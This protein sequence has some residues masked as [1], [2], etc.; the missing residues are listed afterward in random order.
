MGT[1]IYLSWN[2]M[3]EEEK[4]MQTDVGFDADAGE[5]GYLRASIGMVQENRLLRMLFP[6]V[7][8]EPMD[9]GLSYDF[10]KGVELLPKAL[11]QYVAGD[12]LPETDSSRR[13]FQMG[14]IVAKMMTEV[15]DAEIAKISGGRDMDERV[16]YARSVLRFFMFGM[17]LQEEGKN[18][19]VYISW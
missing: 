16:R 9:E 8:W 18:P 3:D 5:I 19:K 10:K 17:R 11:S 15:G 6:E 2:G 7:H 4:K 1:D 12:E 13:Q 14:Q